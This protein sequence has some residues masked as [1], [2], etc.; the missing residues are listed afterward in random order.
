MLTIR[1]GHRVVDTG[2]YRLVR[3]PIYTGFIAAI[4]AFALL[5]TTPAALA[6][7]LLLALTMAAKA[8]TEEHFLRRELGAEAYDAYA[9]KTP[10]LVPFGLV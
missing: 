2:P 6:G 5:R 10:M 4:L 9:R 3:H 8:K 7:A 1:E